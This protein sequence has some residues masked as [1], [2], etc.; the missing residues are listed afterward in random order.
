MASISI[1]YMA[2]A[3]AKRTSSKPN[4]PPNGLSV[5][6]IKPID[7]LGSQ[8]IKI[9]FAKRTPNKPNPVSTG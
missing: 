9:P 6:P 1:Q 3:L 2:K 7:Y 8:Q 5:P 4:Q